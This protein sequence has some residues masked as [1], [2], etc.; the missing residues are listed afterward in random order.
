MTPTKVLRSEFFGDQVDDDPEILRKLSTQKHAGPFIIGKE[1]GRGITGSVRLGIHAETSFKVALK[2]V[3]KKYLN[4][5]PERWNTLRREISVM[6][7]TEHPNIVK[8]YDVFETHD[9][10]YLVTELLTGGELFDYI[11]REGLSRHE[12]LRI[13]AQITSALLHCHEYGIVHRDLKPENLLM[14]ENHN[15]KLGDFG[16][17]RLMKDGAMLK[18]SCGSPHYASPEVIAD[19]KYDGKRSDV[20]SIGVILFAMASGMLPFD[21][22]NIPT[23]LNMVKKGV[24]EMP[25]SL[26]DDV[27]DLIDSMIQV[28]LS[29]RIRMEDILRHSAFRKVPGLVVPLPSPIHSPF[30]SPFHSPINSPSRNSSCASP[31]GSPSSRVVDTDGD[32]KMTDHEFALDESLIDDLLSLGWDSKEELRAKILQSESSQEKSLYNHL[33]RRRRTRIEELQR[34]SPIPA[35]RRFFSVSTVAS[36]SSSAPATP[37]LYLDSLDSRSRRSSCGPPAMD[38]LPPTG[39]PKFDDTDMSMS[40]PMSYSNRVPESVKRIQRIQQMEHRSSSVPS[41]PY[42][43]PAFLTRQ[44][45]EPSKTS[46]PSPSHGQGDPEVT[47]EISLKLF[48]LANEPAAK[49]NCAR[50]LFQT[51][52]SRQPGTYQPLP[53]APLDRRPVSIPDRTSTVILNSPKAPSPRLLPKK[54]DVALPPQNNHSDNSLPSTPMLRWFSAFFRRRPSLDPWKLS[55]T[56]Q[57]NPHSQNH[58]SHVIGQPLKVDPHVVLS[59]PPFTVP[60]PTS[61]LSPSSSSSTSSTSSSS[62][63]LFSLSPAPTFTTVSTLAPSLARERSSSLPTYINSSSSSSSSSSPQN[64][65]PPTT[66]QQQQQQQQQSTSTTAATISTTPKQLIGPAHRK[67]FHSA[68]MSQHYRQLQPRKKE[69]PKPSTRASS[70]YIS[71]NSCRDVEDVPCESIKT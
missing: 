55:G 15:V 26:D 39:F 60:S 68:D 41:S 50:R 31:L 56:A 67:I 11:P 22:Q 49:P 8:L 20:W 17:A 18:T 1:L 71:Q 46:M 33:K 40:V 66:P 53:S 28:D 63:P 42:S 48:S 52:S 2:I 37:S 25:E 36:S 30:H 4:K 21:H 69:P 12:S 35:R 38:P 3:K 24:Y 34:L 43:P 65:R 32:I 23:L 62:S 54:E 57:Q 64:L 27:K 7:V 14:D 13:L 16:M 59:S 58:H 19:G 6:K 51:T 29:K 44:I 61:S 9:K 70:A 10:I 45:S 5:N 47:T